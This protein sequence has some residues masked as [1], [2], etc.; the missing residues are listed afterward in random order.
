[1]CGLVHYVNP[2]RP[3]AMSSSSEPASISVP[4]DYVGLVLLHEEDSS[5]YLQI[6]LDIIGS[7]CLKPRKYLLFL[8]WCVLGV[9]GVL[10]RGRGGGGIDTNGDLDDQGIYYYV[11]TA[12]SGTFFLPMPLLSCVHMEH[13]WRAVCPTKISPRPLTSRSSR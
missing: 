4:P 8:G 3:A 1:M 12:G 13:L 2:R 9:E 6:P 11:A 7:L 10:A 5:F